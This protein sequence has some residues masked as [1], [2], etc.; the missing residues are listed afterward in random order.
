MYIVTGASD[1]HFRSLLQFL[2][3]IPPAQIP[4]T[5]VWDLG[6]SEEHLNSLQSLFPAARLRRFPFAEYP[7]YFNI[8]EAAGQYAWK[9]VAVWRTA[10]ELS[11]EGCGGVL[12][13]CDAGNRIVGALGSIAYVIASQGVYSPLS[14]GTVKQWTHPGCLAFFSIQEGDAM[15]DMSPRN[16]AIVG[17]D[18]D[19]ARAW[20]LLETWVTLA[21]W[22]EC[23]APAGSDRT[24]HRQDQAVFTIL[25]YRYTDMNSLRDTNISLLTHQDCD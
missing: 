16:G 7:V 2:Q 17:F 24:N 22:Q 13:W 15:L 3:S 12:L 10:L 1:N 4:Y 14:A 23:I 9:P 11:N 18:L 19:N 21:Q 20:Q 25:Y 8:K 5:Y 6:L